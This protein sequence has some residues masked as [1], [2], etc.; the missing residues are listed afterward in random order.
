MVTAHVGVDKLEDRIKRQKIIK[1]KYTIHN[2]EDEPIF[3]Q[4]IK[5]AIPFGFKV[6]STEEGRILGRNLILN[7]ELEKGE[8]WDTIIIGYFETPGEYVLEPILKIKN[9]PDIP[10]GAYTIEVPREE[11]REV[12]KK[13][14]IVVRR[15]RVVIKDILEK[16]SYFYKR[17]KY[18]ERKWLEEKIYEILKKKQLAVL[19]TFPG[20]GKTTL[21]AKIAIEKAVPVI[22]IGQQGFPTKTREIIAEIARQIQ[23]Y[24]TISV[25]EN[26]HTIKDALREIVRWSKENNEEPPLII[27]DGIDEAENPEEVLEEIIYPIIGDT[28]TKMIIT[29]RIG[30]EK[31]EKKLKEIYYRLRGR[32]EEII[33]PL[34][35]EDENY[36]KQLEDARK[37]LEKNLP[38]EK[39][40]KEGYS[41]E[42][43]IEILADRS[44]GN[45]MIA[46]TYIRALEEEE[47]TIS[48]I[49]REFPAPI[50]IETW[51]TTLIGII[52]RT[53]GIERRRIE[54]F[55]AIVTQLEPP[56]TKKLLKIVMG[57]EA[58]KLLEATKLLII[59]EENTYRPLHG[60]LQQYMIKDKE[61]RIEVNLEIA[62][63]IRKVIEE[64]PEEI[65]DYETGETIEE[66]AIKNLITYYERAKQWRKLQEF[67][68]K[69]IIPM[70]DF[71]D[72]GMAYKNINAAIRSLKYYPRDE[73]KRIEKLLKYA[74]AKTRIINPE[75]IPTKVYKAMAMIANIDAE[76]NKK[77]DMM[78]RSIKNLTKKLEI[79]TELITDETLRDSGNETILKRIRRELEEA[80]PLPEKY[81]AMVYIVTMLTRMNRIEEAIETAK[82]IEDQKQRSDAMTHIAVKLAEI[83]RIEDAI[84]I[85]ERIEDMREKARALA[86]IA[87]RLARMDRIEE[88]VKIIEKAKEI[89]EEIEN[90]WQRAEIMA[91]I[92]IVLMKMNKLNDTIGIM[93]RARETVERIKNPWQRDWTLAHIATILVETNRTEE[94]IE[95]AKKIEDVAHRVETLVD[96][97]VRLARMDRIEE[98]VKIIEKAKELTEEIKNP[99]QRDWA[100]A[101]IAVK[102]AEM[103]RIEKALETAGRIEDLKRRSWALAD[104][105]SILMEM[106]MMKE[107]VEIMRRAKEIAERIKEVKQRSRTLGY[108]AVKLAEMN[109]IEEALKIAEKIGEAE[110]RAKVLADI[111]IKLIEMRES[112]RAIKMVEKAIKMTGEM[113]DA[114][115]EAKTIAD[116]AVK[117]A[118]MNRIKEAIEMIEKAKKTAER[119]ENAWQ[120]AEM[121]TNIAV[122]LARINE[123]EAIKM[124]EKAKEIA[125]RI[126]NV[127]RRSW[128]M[129]YIVVKL[130]EM[131]RIEDAIEL[132]DRVEN[133]WRKAKTIADIAVKLAEM[134]RIKEAIEMIEKA[135][136]TAERI[137]N[138]LSRVEAM[139]SIAVKLARINKEE[140]IK[141]IEKAKK[142]AR[143]IESTWQRNW[144]LGYIAVKLA[145]M[146]RVEEALKIAEKIGEAEERAKV[147]ADIATILMRMN[148]IEEALKTM[149]KAKEI[150]KRIEGIGPIDWIMTYIAA[151]LA[152]MNRVEEALK[153]AEKIGEAEERAKV[154]ADIAVEL[155]KMGRVS[156]L[157]RRVFPFLSFPE[158]VRALKSFHGTGLFDVIIDVISSSPLSQVDF[159]EVFDLLLNKFPSTSDFLDIVLDC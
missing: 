107:A 84:K 27:L 92:A 60:T 19:R 73:R 83:N 143:G 56:I 94:A 126:E 25:E 123:E 142:T 1:I 81:R 71:L 4:M 12:V 145:E 147:L 89:T 11:I 17:E 59:K 47:L 54:K 6:I 154:L 61:E 31:I 114:E 49:E 90:P 85:A 103:N 46:S 135:K 91:D 122:K 150:V 136:K 132:V 64:N 79:I 118:E 155:A 53:Y 76:M 16:C 98:A 42:K 133:T 32:Y 139:A 8:I 124:I 21:M 72:I 55:L 111:A 20:A 121:M 15:N 93:K 146:N 87:I 29:V 24:W 149:K 120:K 66:Y 26:I 129:A 80:P 48:Q 148:R 130:A 45:F 158:R 86:G 43:A 14:E 157:V 127:K 78:I 153:I 75:T 5:K 74:K 28:E 9:R 18:Q 51:Y 22:L 40:K 116:I 156:L 128:I 141:M 88:A 110:E 33:I 63:K 106:D 39:A 112:E 108:I 38:I 65:I 58:E 105:A 67:V 102:L 100:L 140:A 113:K 23:Y 70:I 3:V 34:K 99:W 50:E 37:Y 138:V 36:R 69:R 30:I 96:I 77:L 134:N 117:L 68:E 97:A 2:D 35:K 159:L 109:R 137:E 95:T 44:A 104:I 144:A 131:N 151:K 101:H 82:R 13:E 152:E 125:G 10:I 41:L 62:E 7:K 119:I 52:E 115:R 57:E